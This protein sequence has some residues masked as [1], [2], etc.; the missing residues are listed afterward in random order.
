V[1]DGSIADL[2]KTI[3]GIEEAAE[4]EENALMHNR[5]TL[6][7]HKQHLQAI[8]DQLFTLCQIRQHVQD[9]RRAKDQRAYQNITESTG[10]VQTAP[11]A[12]VSVFKSIINK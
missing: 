5:T 9:G 3:A 12:K 11:A 6:A 4:Q 2:S 10:T 8:R 7:L 1:N